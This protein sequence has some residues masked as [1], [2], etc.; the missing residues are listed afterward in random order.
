MTEP[1]MQVAQWIYDAFAKGDVPCVL[2][3]IHDDI[4]WNEAN[5]FPYPDSNPDIGPKAVL[6]GVFALCIGE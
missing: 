4:V 6:N 1:V 2:R 3:R 5:N